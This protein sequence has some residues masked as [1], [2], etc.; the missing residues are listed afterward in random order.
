MKTVDFPPLGTRIPQVGLG[1]GRLDGRV[2]LRHSVRVIETALELGIRYFDVAPLY[3][4]GTAEGALGSALRGVPDAI[5]ASKVGIPR[6]PYQPLRARIRA[7][8][9]PMLD[10]SMPAK[11]M[12][13]RLLGRPRAHVEARP[14]RFSR[15]EILRSVEDSLRRLRRERIDVLLAHDPVLAD[16]GAQERLAFEEVVDRG[17]ARAFGVGTD[18]VAPPSACGPFGQVWQS[19]WPGESAVADYSRDR[20]LVFHG[21]VRS[22][23]AGPA[24]QIR[25]HPRE[26]L[27]RA[28]DA[29]PDALII[30]SASTP[31]RLREL[32]SR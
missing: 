23:A 25:P 18:A 27:F 4:M 21:V 26:L 8:A 11:F 7:L 3:G 12:L 10:R 16:L 22:A 6:P 24:G 5:I 29:A 9:K 31:A 13:R 14:M 15:E 17:L 28:T 19:R 30:V 20:M 32:L 1:C 2:M